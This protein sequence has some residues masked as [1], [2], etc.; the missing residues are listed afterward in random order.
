MQKKEKGK[1][2]IERKEKNR[3]AADVDSWSHN[4]KQ[5]KETPQEGKAS[6]KKDVTPCLWLYYFQQDPPP[7]I[8]TILPVKGY[9][10]FGTVSFATT[11]MAERICL[12]LY[13]ISFR[14][15]QN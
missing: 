14:P 15:T 3:I 13:N 11:V 9:F 10:T 5:E 6:R 4:P 2:K 8:A 7:T 1:H 12:M